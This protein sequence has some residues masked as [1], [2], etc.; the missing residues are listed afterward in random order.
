MTETFGQ[1]A[2]A[3]LARAGDPDALPVLLP[4]VSLDGTAP[5]RARAPMLATC[6]LDGAPI[7]PAFTTSDLGEFE[8]GALR[9]RGRIDDTIITGGHNVHPSEVEAVVAATPG[10][11]AACAFGV[12]DARWGQIVGAA[13]AV[14]AAFAID[15]AV[16]HWQAALPPHAR[17][18]RLAICD[19]IPQLPS[20]K[21]DR[22]AASALATAPVEYH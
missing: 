21:H 15:A 8:T 17:P 7:A 3:P 14:D 19:A 1:I 20:G 12:P 9:V 16:A 5:I 22:H 4:G 18:R 10:V 13:I 2:T 6:Y 11:R